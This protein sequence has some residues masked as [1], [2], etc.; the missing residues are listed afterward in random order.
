MRLKTFQR[1]MDTVLQGLTCAFVYLG[2]IL[3]ASSSEQEHLQDIRSV[4]SRLRDAGLVIKLEKCLFGLKSLAF[5]GHQVSQFGSTPTAIKGQSNRRFPKAIHSQRPTGISRDDQLIPP[6]SFPKPRHFSCFTVRYKS[7]HLGKFSAGQ[8]KRTTLSHQLKQPYQK[9]PCSATPRAV[10]EQYVQGVWQPFAFL[11]KRLRPPEKKYSTFDREL[12][13]LYVA[14]R[15]FRFFLEGR[16]FTAYT[17]HKPL[18]GAM[19][20]LSDP[21]TARQQ[22][23]VGVTPN[24]ND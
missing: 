8:Q 9:P 20:K 3:V 11:S 15:H 6:G 16:P 12:L 17:D 2:D 13:G 21:R 23:H 14:I 24:C 19:S 18:V 7:Q 1:L 22:H 4:C 10:L 5:L